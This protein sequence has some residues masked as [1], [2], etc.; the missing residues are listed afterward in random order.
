M[1]RFAAIVAIA[2]ASVVANAG[3]YESF[4]LGTGAL[5]QGFQIEQGGVGTAPY[6]MNAQGNDDS[7]Q[8]FYVMRFDL[9]AFSGAAVQGVT[10]DLTH[11]EAFFS[12]SGL[13]QLSYSTD[14]SFDLNSLVADANT[15]GGNAQLAASQVALFDFVTGNDGVTDTI[16]LNDVDGLFADIESGSMITL[17]LEAAESTTSATY[18]GLGNTANGGPVLNVVVPTR[19]SLALIGLGGLISTRRRRA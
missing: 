12:T 11:S 7:F 14:D 18:A 13:V 4:E 3:V 2:G 6:F 17:I 10:I 9:S 16:S 8:E 5:D 15:V 19:G 1:N